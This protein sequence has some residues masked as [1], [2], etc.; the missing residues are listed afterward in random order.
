MT[1]QKLMQLLQPLADNNPEVDVDLVY[2]DHSLG[3]NVRCAL[4]VVQS[5]MASDGVFGVAL[6][7][8]RKVSGDL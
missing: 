4:E 6:V 8:G 5:D 1:I 2:W 7:S 3:E